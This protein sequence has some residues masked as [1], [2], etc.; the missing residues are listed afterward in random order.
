M[1]KILQPFW[2]K[3]NF[4]MW[5]WRFR[6]GAKS[7]YYLMFVCPQETTC[8]QLDGFDEIRYLKIF[9]KYVEKKEASL[10]YGKNKEYFTWRP[11]RSY[12]NISLKSS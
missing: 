10:E 3:Y 8:L 12:D 7:D 9:W 2:T 1:C 5:F 6:N 4:H 11:M